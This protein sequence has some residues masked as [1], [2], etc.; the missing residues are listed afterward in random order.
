MSGDLQHELPV[1]AFVEQRAHIRSLHRQTAE[2]KRPRCETQVLCFCSPA[3]PERVELSRS[4]ELSVSRQAVRGADVAECGRLA[5]TRYQANCPNCDQ[6]N[7]LATCGSRP[8]SSKLQM[9]A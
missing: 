5:E 9:R 7:S 6:L 8:D 2:D 1:T 4:D 3:S